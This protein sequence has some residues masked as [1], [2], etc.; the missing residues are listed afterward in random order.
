MERLPRNAPFIV[1]L[2]N[3]AIDFFQCFQVIV[4]AQTCDCITDGSDR[5][6]TVSS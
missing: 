3:A 2:A 6:A 1:G 4:V 5:T